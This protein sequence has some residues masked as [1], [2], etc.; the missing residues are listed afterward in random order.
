MAFPVI[1]LW[2][3]VRMNESCKAMANFN[4]DEWNS[5]GV[6]P[7]AVDRTSPGRFWLTTAA[8]VVLEAVYCSIGQV[9]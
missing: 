5:S 1:W 9:S 3:I 7:V 6:P 8:E 4:F 2:S